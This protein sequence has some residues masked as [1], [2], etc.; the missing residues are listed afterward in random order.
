MLGSPYPVLVIGSIKQGLV[1]VIV[2]SEILFIG[3]HKSRQS[4]Q[5]V[6]LAY[7]R[8]T[9]HAGGTSS[10]SRSVCHGA[11]NPY[12][13]VISLPMSR[14][15]CARCW[16]SL[17]GRWWSAFTRMHACTHTHTHTHQPS[18]FWFPPPPPTPLVPG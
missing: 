4:H 10:P 17:D 15:G 11:S 9:I 5:G 12:V 18:A 13:M 7:R 3:W 14:A 2:S 6:A 16:C 1:T 8:A